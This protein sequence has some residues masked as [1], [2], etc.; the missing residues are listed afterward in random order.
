MQ[1]KLMENFTSSTTVRDSGNHEEAFRKIIDEENK[2]R[3]E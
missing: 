2:R 3:E 1:K